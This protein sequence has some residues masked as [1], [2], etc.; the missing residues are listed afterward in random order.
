MA[1]ERKSKRRAPKAEEHD[2]ASTLIGL[3]FERSGQGRSA[4]A[5]RDDTPIDFQARQDSIG[6]T[7][8]NPDLPKVKRTGAEPERVPETK[9]KL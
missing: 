4:L 9:L 2:T 8:R 3:A 6:E 7:R 5:L 1:G